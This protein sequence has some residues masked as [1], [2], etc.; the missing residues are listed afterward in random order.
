MLLQA[1]IL[2]RALDSLDSA[3]VYKI[4]WSADVAD[5]SPA[6]SEFCAF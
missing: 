6:R 4:P 3:F 1:H 5:A 2:K